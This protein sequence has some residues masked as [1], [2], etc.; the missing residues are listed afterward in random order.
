M[1][2]LIGITGQIG[3]GKSTAAKVFAKLGAAVINADKIGRQVV[4]KNPAL[5]SKLA[6]AFGSEVLNPNG[7]LKRKR[8]AQI[9]FS[10]KSNKKRLD[11]LVHPFLLKELKRQITCLSK[12]HRVIVIDAALFL[13]WNLDKITDQVLLIH[14]SEKIRLSRMMS[15]GIKI[16]DAKARQKWQMKFSKMRKRADKIILNNTSKIEFELKVR[17]WAGQFF[18]AS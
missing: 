5:T 2:T 9:A 16:A 7:S 8:V 14:G 1:P 11:S 10:N 17:N 12:S 3:S 15:R 4:E 13:D 6:G 18:S